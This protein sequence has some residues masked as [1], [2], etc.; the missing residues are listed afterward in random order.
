MPAW[1][2]GVFVSLHCREQVPFAARP[3]GVRRRGWHRIIP[4]E[5]EQPPADIATA[6]PEIQRFTARHA[7]A[8][9]FDCHDCVDHH[10]LL[11]L[12]KRDI[13]RG[14]RCAP[15]LERTW[16]KLDVVDGTR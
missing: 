16:M 7:N 11:A 4:A 8:L 3:S 13:P 6:E 2:P 5:R 12:A 14:D 1:Q 10:M 15:P 9:T